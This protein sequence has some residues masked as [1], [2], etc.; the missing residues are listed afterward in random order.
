MAQNHLIGAVAN[1]HIYKK[2]NKEVYTHQEKKCVIGNVVWICENAII[3]NGVKIG[4]GAI[5]AAGAVVTRGVPD[6]AVVD[7]VLARIIKCRFDEET[8]KKVKQS[9]RKLE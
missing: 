9:I 4:D 5:V 7:G 6:Y 8:I 1:H 2:K 3:I